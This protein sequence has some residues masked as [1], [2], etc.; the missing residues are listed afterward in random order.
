KNAQDVAVIVNHA[1]YAEVI[2]DMR[3]NEGS[4][5]LATRKELAKEAFARTAMYDMMIAAYLNGAFGRQRTQADPHD[6]GIG[7][8]GGGATF[9]RLS[10]KFHVPP[11]KEIDSDEFS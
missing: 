1:L 2:R 10:S 3:E 6:A 7:T 9:S 8:G 4:L 5:T 11:P